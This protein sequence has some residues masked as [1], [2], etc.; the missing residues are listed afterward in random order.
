MMIGRGVEGALAVLLLL[1]AENVG[2]TAIA[3]EKVR[4]VVAI[5]EFPERLD[6]AD[7]HQEIVL[8]GQRE[9]GVDQIVPRA[10]VAQMD[11]EA[12]GEEGEEPRNLKPLNSHRRI[13]P[14]REHFS[15]SISLKKVDE[16]LN[17][18]IKSLPDL[19]TRLRMSSAD[20]LGGD[21]S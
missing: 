3:D 18:P 17:Q 21:A 1:G 13:A 9:D 4:A 10:G 8:A 12:V 2:G 6:A 20:Q 7:D 5:E 11:F 19:W 16:R 15:K 14:H